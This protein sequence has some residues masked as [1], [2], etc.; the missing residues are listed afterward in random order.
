MHG[1]LQA[2][3][4]PRLGSGFA[5]LLEMSQHVGR[6][7]AGRGHQKGGVGPAQGLGEEGR[8]VKAAG[9]GHGPRL[10]QGVEA[11]AGPGYG[12]YVVVL[13]EQ[14]VNEGGADVAGSAENGDFL[15]YL[16]KK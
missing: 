9:L 6:G 12:R 2:G 11:G 3:G 4:A 1:L 5:H 8:V 10:G 15:G 16:I 14:V 13:V 7:H